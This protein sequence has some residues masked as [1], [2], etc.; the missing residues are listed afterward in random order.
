L[1]NAATGITFANRRLIIAVSSWSKKP[2]KPARRW[3]SWRIKQRFIA[4]SQMNVW[5]RRCVSSRL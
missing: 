3:S 4:M 1:S 5:I 2:I